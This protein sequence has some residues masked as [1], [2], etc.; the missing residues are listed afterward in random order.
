MFKQDFALW[1]DG[2][3]KRYRG[4]YEKV[5]STKK[6]SLL[7][8]ILAEILYNTLGHLRRNLTKPKPFRHNTIRRWEYWFFQRLPSLQKELALDCYQDLL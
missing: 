1:M 2:W 5:T 7:K 6:E 8:I 4:Y 3:K